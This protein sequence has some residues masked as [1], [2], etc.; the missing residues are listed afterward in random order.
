[1]EQKQLGLLLA[2]IIGDSYGARYEFKSSDQV[3]KKLKE[4]K[5]QIK[6]LGGGH[7]RIKPGQVTDD[8]EM[9]MAL[10]SSLSENNG[11]YDQFK[12]ADKYIKWH[13]SYPFDEGITTQRA[14]NKAKSL[15]DVLRNSRQN[16]QSSLSNGCLMRIW[17]LMFYYH[18]KSNDEIIVAA[19]RD[20]EITHPNAICCYIVTAFCLMLKLAMNDQTKSKNDIINVLDLYDDPVIKSIKESVSNN[21]NHIIL[22]N[23][24]KKK[25]MFNQ[26]GEY[27]GYIGLTLAIVLKEFLRHD[28]FIDY[29]VGIS[30]YGG[31]TDTNC[32]I[33][34]ALF[35]AYYGIRKI[36]KKYIEQVMTVNCKRYQNYPLADISQ[37]ISLAHVRKIIHH[38]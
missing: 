37:F 38:K 23:N 11:T 4:D 21:F 20:C 27:M 32:C 25:V 36:P 12:S 5:N 28:N 9:A 26:S 19:T 22:Q 15:K 34:S 10:L 6:L 30:S 17:S 13:N 24:Q 16:N 31:D 2:A 1:M 7:W 33:G 8:S 29:L 3:I 35:G 18:N 14:F